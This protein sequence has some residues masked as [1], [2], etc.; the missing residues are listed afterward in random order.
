M[1]KLAILILIALAGIGIYSEINAQVLGADLR[2]FQV[3]QGGTGRARLDSNALLIGNGTG[4]INSTSSPTVGFITATSTT[5]TSTMAGNLWVQSNLRVGPSEPTYKD[6][7][8]SVADFISDINN[9]S[10]VGIQ[11]KNAGAIASSDLVFGNNKTTVTDYYADCGIA[12]GNNN[13]PIYTG[14]GGANW[15]YCFNTDAGMSFG[16]GTTTT[17]SD[18]R[19]LTGAD[20]YLTSNIKMVLTNAG[21]LGVGA[22]TSL[23]QKLEVLS[24]NATSTGVGIRG[25]ST[26]FGAGD[27]AM[28]NIRASD[29]AAYVK[30]IE[31]N[32]FATSN[33]SSVGISFKITSLSTAAREYARIEA[34][35]T[36]SPGAS[37]AALSFKTT[38]DGINVTEALRID[39]NGN[40]GI[41]TSTPTNLLD[42]YGSNSNTTLTTQGT[43]TI[44]IV[45]SNTTNNNFSS[46]AGA[47]VAALTGAQINTSRIAFIHE[48]HTSG[49]EDGEISIMTRQNGTMG[50]VMRLTNDNNVGIGTTTPQSRLH[51]SGGANGVSST[52]LTLENT[53][54]V[55]A[56]TGSTIDFVSRDSGPTWYSA[57][58]IGTSLITGGAGAATSDL[59]F[60]V[61]GNGSSTEVFRLTGDG[62]FEKRSQTFPNSWILSNPDTTI[63]TGETVGMFAFHTDDASTIPNRVV[64]SIDAIADNDF[65]GTD[66]VAT[67][68]VFSTHPNGSAKTEKMRIT[69]AGNVGIGTTS[70]VN[71]LHVYA[72]GVTGLSTTGAFRIGEGQNGDFMYAGM[73]DA[74]ASGNP[75]FYLQ[76]ISEGTAFRDIALNPSGGNVGIGTTTPVANFQVTNSSANATTSVQFGKPG[77]NKGTCRT[78]YDTAGSPVYIYI[79]AGATSYTFQNGGTAPS[80]CQN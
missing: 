38:T 34:I 80:G 36:N 46:L 3:Q 62:L 25:S 77:Q 78:E 31:L 61:Y 7:Y 48:D 57:A 72:T 4:A 41:G 79:A 65:T 58:K 17:G 54:G 43:P 69:G 8:L 35:R 52:I 55:N 18:F 6:D 64:A 50:E 44:A 66:N 40:I 9:Y 5:A 60:N 28:L 45:N 51:I 39:H 33:N 19:W 37:D 47:T 12:G 75:Y 10:F 14:L 27:N 59:Y 20:S 73:V 42:V 23:T 70:P 11:N 68:L 56:G 74:P 76:A 30:A 16:I 71:K 21:I 53:T 13:D 32:N 29:E 15:F 49:S 24:T 63:T 2:V 26:A 67:S 1:K 22:T